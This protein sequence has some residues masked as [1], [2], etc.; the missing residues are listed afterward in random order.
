[1]VNLIIKNEKEIESA[2]R[3]QFKEICVKKSAFYEKLFK[4]YSKNLTLEVI[5]NKSSDTYLLSISIDLK[6]K[7]ILVAHEDRDI[8]KLTHFVWDEFKNAVTHHY[9]KEKEERFH[10]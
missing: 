4:R 8:I 3:E 5:V 9:E 1:M 2:Y 6:S 7:K 10:K